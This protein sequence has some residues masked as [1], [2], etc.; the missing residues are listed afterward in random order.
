VDAAAP[1][2]SSENI[3]LRPFVIWDQSDT[4]DD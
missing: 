1:P 4:E 2:A 3:P